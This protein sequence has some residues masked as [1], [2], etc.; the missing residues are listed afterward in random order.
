MPN[1][2]VSRYLVRFL[3]V[4]GFACM[5][6]VL[7]EA[8]APA[9]EGPTQSPQDCATCHVDVV[10]AW[11]DSTHAQAYAD[12]AFQ[13][14]WH[15]QDDDLDCLA[16]HTSGFDGVSGE[17]MQE[18]VTCIACHGETP[19]DHPPEPVALNLG[20]ETC[21]ECHPT[22]Y[23]EW[24]SSDHGEQQLACTT[25]HQP[26]PQELRFVTEE[27]PNA[28]CLNC[29]NES[30]RSDYTHLLHAEQRCVDCHWHRADPSDYDLHAVTGALFPT[31][32]EAN[33]EPLACVTC[34]QEFA[35]GEA[36][37]AVL[38]AQDELTESEFTSEH[39]LL[40]AQV[41]IEELEAE[42][43]TVDAQGANTS[44][45]RLAQGVVVGAVLGGIL[46][47]AASLF[48]RRSPQVAAADSDSDAHTD[49]K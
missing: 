36:G 44:S 43:D 1:S 12:P 40:E 33:V 49:D 30:G 38:E 31:G 35:I 45:L 19:A 9:Q 29:H 24:Q 34:H 28:L 16:C 42:L 4:V 46:I 15:A 21:A 26:H 8:G 32:H 6:A 13:E 14:A 23:N 20:V 7:A 39:P 22:T 41:R 11:Q 48:R 18:G 10:A 3:I 17:Y 2:F 37:A 27:E 25:C 47:F 5:G